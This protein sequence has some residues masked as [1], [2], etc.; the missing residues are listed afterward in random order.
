MTLISLPRAPTFNLGGKRA[1]VTGA[2]RGIGLGAAA[3][4]AQA[5]A[6]VTLC[7]RSPE[8]L[9]AL[10]DAIRRDGGGAETLTLDITDVASTMAALESCPP[11]D[12]LVNNA[13]TNRIA[14]F[15]QVGLGDF[16][17][18]FALN[19]KASYF[20]AQSVA[21]R[22]MAAGRTGASGAKQPSMRKQNILEDDRE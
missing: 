3:A 17:A 14:P 11:F 8:E 21:R 15:T 22:L 10:R 6:H 18:V 4:L 20:V 5:G 13:G 16:D 1:L 12:I 9:D 7:A 2:G 19:V